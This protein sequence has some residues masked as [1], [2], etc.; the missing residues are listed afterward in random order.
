M[1]IAHMHYYQ[2]SSK[3]YEK[4]VPSLTSAEHLN[5]QNLSKNADCSECNELVLHLLQH[6]KLVGGLW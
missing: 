6:Y 1:M 4:F 5:K 2:T 3:I